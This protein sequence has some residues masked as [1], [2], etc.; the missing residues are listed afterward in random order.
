VEF[1]RLVEREMNAP[2]LNANRLA[3]VR[4]LL[5]NLGAFLFAS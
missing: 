5:E 2:T 3:Q 1:I 4:A